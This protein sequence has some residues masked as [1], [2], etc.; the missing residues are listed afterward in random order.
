MMKLR[1]LFLPLVAL[2]MIVTGCSREKALFDT[3]P[4]NAVMVAS[5]NVKTFATDAG[6]KLDA[7]G[8]VTNPDA[9]PVGRAVA[10][11]LALSKAA[12]VDHTVVV[13]LTQQEAYATVAVTDADLFGKILD[14]NGFERSSAGSYDAFTSHGFTIL[15]NDKQ[16][17]LLRDGGPEKALQSL[18]KVLKQ[19][20]DKGSVAD[21]EA[22]VEALMASTPYNFIATNPLTG[23]GGAVAAEVKDNKLQG[24][25]TM[26]P[27]ADGNNAPAPS[28]TDINLPVLEYVPDNACLV[29]A[30]G[31][32]K[33]IDWAAR[34]EAIAN[35]AGL[36]AMER[37][38][39]SMVNTYLSALDGTVLLAISP[40]DDADFTNLNPDQFDLLAMVHMDQDMVNQTVESLVQMAGQAGMPVNILGSGLYAVN[41]NGRPI[42]FGSVDGYLTVSTREPSNNHGSSLSAKFSGKKGALMA[43][44]PTLQGLFPRATYGIDFLMTSGSKEGTFTLTT[45]AP[46]PI[47]ATLLGTK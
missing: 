43:H 27:L 17:W 13:A 18:N 34:T 33:D 47:L 4:A 42:Y 8:Q 45:T 31:L 10:S 32:S 35:A 12:D 44:I 23:E 6:F 5:V 14:D 3:I 9:A 46:G 29:T 11:I 16:A 30:A 28:L 38:Q 2:L 26:L 1:N 7:D 39:L 19:A 24:R 15:A 36:N 22:A 41:F 20:A 25:V 40:K 37:A 21:N